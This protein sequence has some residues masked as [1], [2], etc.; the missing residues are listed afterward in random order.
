MAVDLST[1]SGFPNGWFVAAFSDELAPGGVQPIRYFA[2]DMVLFRTEAGDAVILDAHCPHMG[3]HLGYDSVVK[4]GCIECPFHA[5]VFDNNGVC[6]HIPYQQEIPRKARLRAWH[7]AERNGMI[8]VWH[9]REG[10]APSWQIPEL[11]EHGAQGWTTWGHSRMDIKTHPKEIIEN[12]ADKQH[13]PR[14][15]RTHLTRFDNVFE[16]HVATQI[17]E[18]VAYPRPGQKDTF[19]LDATY[20]G[21]AYQIT[22]M[23]GVLSSV[24]VNAHT[25]IEDKLLHL[26]FGVMIRDTGDRARNEKFKA[27]YVDNLTKGF[28]EDVAIWEH[29]VY[30]KSPLLL[31][32]DGPIG[33]VRRWYGQFYEGG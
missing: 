1:V 25:P 15:H 28:L 27:G 9:H 30:R 22:K 14:V 21:P 11:V 20:Y 5:W 12:V 33:K 18:G 3:A 32:N 23:D 2:T 19:K 31:K 26:R 16:G 29:K 4:D 7:V 17:T 24:L 6:T 8:F 13:F 10:A